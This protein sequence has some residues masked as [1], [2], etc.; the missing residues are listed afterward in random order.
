V[1]GS[2]GGE[3]RRRTGDSD[4]V[5]GLG[6]PPIRSNPASRSTGDIVMGP[7]SGTGGPG[8]IQMGARIEFVSADPPIP[9]GDGVDVAN[10]SP[11]GGFGFGLTSGSENSGFPVGGVDVHRVPLGSIASATEDKD[12]SFVFVRSQALTVRVPRA[13]A[14]RDDLEA[15]DGALASLDAFERSIRN[16]LTGQTGPFPDRVL[17]HINSAREDLQSR[18]RNHMSRASNAAEMMLAPANDATV[19]P[20]RGH[21]KSIE[22]GH[23][24]LVRR[25]LDERPELSLE[26]QQRVNGLV[27]QLSD[28]DTHQAMLEPLAELALQV[29]FDEFIPSRLLEI[30]GDLHAS[31]RLDGVPVDAA[32]QVLILLTRAKK[33]VDRTFTVGLRSLWLLVPIVVA[34]VLL[35]VPLA[36]FAA[37]IAPLTLAAA[38]GAHT[39]QLVNHRR[40]EIEEMCAGL[41]P[42]L[43]ALKHRQLQARLLKELASGSE[44]Q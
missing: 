40:R 32:E 8:D 35:G 29:E 15:V 20:Y 12:E 6:A 7:S 30:V 27:A 43:P 16:T 10:V 34:L 14:V 21:P 24:P 11:G 3:P 13:I 31:W 18:K 33:Q 19:G 23:H 36:A 37:C 41:K 5:M 2:L 25:L 4:I 1:K 39:M 26:R 22:H 9:K 42:L 44:P 38:A 17:H 28:L